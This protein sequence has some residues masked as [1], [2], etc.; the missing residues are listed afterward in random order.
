MW[1]HPLAS[2]PASSFRHGNRDESFVSRGFIEWLRRIQAW[3]GYI[4][5]ADFA[6]VLDLADL[7]SVPDAGSDVQAADHGVLARV[8]VGL[9]CALAGADERCRFIAERAALVGEDIVRET[10]LSRCWEAPAAVLDVP[11]PPGGVGSLPQDSDER[12][13]SYLSSGGYSV[14][15]SCLSKRRNPESILYSLSANSIAALEKA[16]IPLGARLRELRTANAANKLCL[17]VDECRPAE[18]SQTY[19][20]ENF[21]HDVIEGLFICAYVAGAKEVV[22]WCDRRHR[23]VRRLLETEIAR[24][25]ASGIDCPSRFVFADGS[26]NAEQGLVRTLCLGESPMAGRTSSVLIVSPEILRWI[27]EILAMGL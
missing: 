3:R 5:A 19:F 13:Q 16:R 1:R 17:I 4:S 26:S 21:T 25:K 8:C 10:C 15:K 9:P 20:I 18:M 2:Q 12:L 23:R 14:F 22:I 24:T 11:L 6:S 7:D 27:P